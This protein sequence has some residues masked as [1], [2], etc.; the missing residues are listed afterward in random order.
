MISRII[1][2]L[3][4][5]DQGY[6]LRD[7]M[8]IG[9]FSR[10]FRLGSLH[11]S[12][13]QRSVNLVSNPPRLSR[14]PLANRGI[15]DQVNSDILDLG[16]AEHAAVGQTLTLAMQRLSEHKDLQEYLHKE[17]RDNRTSASKMPASRQQ[18]D[19]CHNVVIETLR[20]RGRGPLPRVGPPPWGAENINLPAWT[21]VSIPLY[22]SHRN[23]RVFA[24]P[25]Q[26][27]PMR[28]VDT[29]AEVA[30]S[31]QDEGKKERCQSDS[32]PGSG[33]CVEDDLAMYTLRYALRAVYS[34][35]E[36]ENVEGGIRFYPVRDSDV[37]QNLAS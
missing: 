31:A 35:F 17:F 33:I 13:Q 20:L 8:M 9:K 24:N 18:L 16:V 30:G 23:P 10:F 28:W 29:S 3:A 22:V 34:R 12:S 4:S 11:S 15:Y 25:T 14:G 5:S 32:L 26:W 37:A 6:N 7:S 27:D 19:L 2:C 1:T 21:Q 36:S